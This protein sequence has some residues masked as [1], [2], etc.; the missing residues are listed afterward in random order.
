MSSKKMKYD[1]GATRFGG[2]GVTKGSRGGLLGN[3][4]RPSDRQAGAGKRRKPCLATGCPDP[5]M[6]GSDYCGKHD[7]GTRPKKRKGD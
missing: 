1:K 2:N 7:N 6:K 4:M 3:V 5:H